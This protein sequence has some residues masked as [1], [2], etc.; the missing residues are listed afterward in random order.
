MISDSIETFITDRDETF[1]VEYT[2]SPGVPG[3]AYKKNGDP[4][5]PP[6]DE[7]IEITSV[8]AWDED[9]NL[10]EDISQTMSEEDR[11]RIE[12]EISAFEAGKASG[13]YDEYD[14]Y[15]DEEELDGYSD[16]PE[17]EDEELNAG[18]LPHGIED[19]EA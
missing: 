13:E 1:L 17:D 2:F 6:E 9:M 12:D 18:I 14:D 16:E 8:R 5:D 15:D 4:G 10:G 7:E 3:V 11:T 19:D